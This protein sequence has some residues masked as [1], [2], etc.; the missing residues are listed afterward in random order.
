MPKKGSGI[1]KGPWAK[2]GRNY[3]RKTGRVVTMPATYGHLAKNDLDAFELFF[4][5]RSYPDVAKKYQ[6]TL[7]GVYKHAQKHEW[8][9]RLAKRLEKV[10][11]LTDEKLADR[12][13]RDSAK[14]Y[15]LMALV[16]V[17]AG[18]ILRRPNLQAGQSVAPSH[19]AMTASALE[20]AI[21]VQRLI[22]GE[23]TDKKELSVKD[24]FLEMARERDRRAQA[25]LPP[26]PR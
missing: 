11:E 2:D 26:P 3:V 13:A 20:T 5:T 6:V 21:K 25:D 19:L 16:Q 8:L 23:T 1:G 14:H 7:P 24:L 18:N 12:L 9:S 4:Q 17:N 15:N 10:Q 22:G